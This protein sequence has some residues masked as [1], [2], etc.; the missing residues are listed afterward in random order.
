MA[1]LQ[2]LA[3]QLRQRGDAGDFLDQI[4][5]AQHIRPPGGRRGH[6]AVQGEAKGVQGGAL[7]GLGDVDA[8]KAD[9]AGGFELIG[10]AGIERSTVLGQI[11]RLAAAEIKDHLGGKIK[12]RQGEGRVDAAF[13]AIA[14]IG[15]DLQRTAGGGDGDRIP[16]GGFDEDIGGLGRAARGLAAHD[17]GKGFNALVVRDRHLTGAQG[18]GLAVEGKEFLATGGGMDAQLA[19]DLGERQRRAAGGSGRW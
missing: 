6:I 8:D 2:R 13:E 15:V 14:R 5:L 9:D 11:R 19:L 12:A 4:R 10:A 3:L 1:R 18:V 7:F 17:T 16:I